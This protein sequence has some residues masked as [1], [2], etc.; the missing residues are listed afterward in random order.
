MPTLVEPYSHLVINNPR[1]QGRPL[2]AKGRAQESIR[3]GFVEAYRQLGGVDGLVKWGKRKPDLFYPMLTKLLPAELAE[4]GNG[5]PIRVLVYAPSGQ[6]LTEKPVELAT[7][8][9]IPHIEHGS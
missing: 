7:S 4:S 6:C 1:R 3:W 8:A 9:A 2:G 5:Q